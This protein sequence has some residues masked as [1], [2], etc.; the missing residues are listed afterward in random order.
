MGNYNQIK[1]ETLSSI[2]AA[3]AILNKFPALSQGNTMLSF[4]T[5]SDPFSFL[6]DCFKSTVGYNILLD[7]LSS[8][9]SSSLPA[10]EISVKSV[11]LANI[12]NLLTCSLNPFITDEIL[13]DG[14]MFDLSQIDI[15]DKLRYSP[16]SEIGK[17]Y[18]FGCDKCETAIDV[19]DTCTKRSNIFKNTFGG[20]IPTLHNSDNE[21][22]DFDCLL[23][24]MKNRAYK[25]EVWSKD[26][27]EKQ[28]NADT[29]TVKRDGIVTLEYNENYRSLR[30]AEGK[31][32]NVQTP[33]FNGI[34][35]FIGDAQ[36]ILTKDYKDLEKELANIDT[37]IKKYN[38]DISE[39]EKLINKNK[40]NIETLEKQFIKNKISKDTFADS[41][42][43]LVAKN[44]D[45]DKKKDNLYNER[46][47]LFSDKGKILLKLRSNM[48]GLEYRKIDKNYYY[49]KTLLEFNTDYVT[50]LRLFDSKVVAAQLIDSMTGLLSIN[51]LLSYK[52]L[53]I[54]NEITKMATMVLD[55]DDAVV[56]DCFFSFSNEEYSQMLEKSNLNRMGFYSSD[57]N[58]MSSSQIDAENILSQLNTINESST[59]EHINTVVKDSL[60]E[61]SRQISSADY[62]QKDKV[63]FGLQM[64]FIENLM[65]N[66]SYV[67]ANSIFS[68]KVYLLIL[69]NLKILG[70]DV[71]FNL[72]GFITRFSQ[73][74]TNLIRSIR[75]YLIEYLVKKLMAILTDLSKEIALK[76][77]DEQTYYYNR[78]LK[79]L[80]TCIK[81]S[82]KDSKNDIDFTIDTIDYAD[83]YNQEIQNNNKIC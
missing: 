52:Q 24:Y 44:N 28:K 20:F 4:N 77:T 46:N 43:A 34:H 49:H 48:E 65:T 73:L 12:K 72:E 68:P 75:D 30:D 42:K 47:H 82:K 16:L 5:T 22:S 13:R 2:D 1:S 59:E 32:I 9:I 29:I 83:I 61:I 6:M 64:N 62:L 55:S 66:L 18:Y 36:E 60:L 56:N 21:S 27:N 37:K 74:I 3:M 58:N 69:I 41:K 51:A 15:S 26:P 23:W 40:Q 38:V 7:I 67:I 31:P 35:V 39:T 19:R 17:F 79:Q 54:R 76:I 14:V 80:F 81:D 50:S 78:L 57:G 45:L 11:L 63:N 71:N 70:Q 8:F 25:R 53:L 10:L 33:Y